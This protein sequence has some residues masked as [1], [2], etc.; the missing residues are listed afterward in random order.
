MRFVIL[1]GGSLFL[2]P[3]ASAQFVY[4]PVPPTRT[5][6]IVASGGPST[7]RET[8]ALRRDIRRGRASGTVSR[9]EARALRRETDQIDTLAERYGAD[10]LS[11]AEARELNTRMRVQHDLVN[12]WRTR[13]IGRA[14]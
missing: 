10:G 14:N 13:G 7:A 12:T 9:R 6:G 11:D 4:G 8:S 3:T 2:S 5:P 1:I